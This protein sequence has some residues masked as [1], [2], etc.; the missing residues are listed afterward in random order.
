MGACS[1]T[2]KNTCCCCCNVLHSILL[3]TC[4]SLFIRSKEIKDFKQY[5][6]CTFFTRVEISLLLKMFKKIGAKTFEDKIHVEDVC[7]KFAPLKNNPFRRMIVE[8]FSSNKE[9][10]SFDE[11]VDMLSSFSPRSP[12]EIKS[13]AIFYVFDSRS[14]DGELDKEDLKAVISK[15]TNCHKT[16][17]TSDELDIAASKMFDELNFDCVKNLSM[18]DFMR[19]LPYVPEF[20]DC[21]TININ[22]LEI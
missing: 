15:M 20:K 18:K 12:P 17:L 13:Q 14:C 19:A 21:W 8:T 1:T 3:T 6:E 5:D 16:Q 7:E 11:F 4:C 9:N 22:W 10:L 2:L